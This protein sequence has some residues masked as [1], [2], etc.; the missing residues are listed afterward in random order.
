M[1]LENGD[2]E[3]GSETGFYNCV[4]YPYNINGR[5]LGRAEKKMDKWSP[6][7]RL[8]GLGFYIGICIVAGILG[9]LWLDSK[10]NTQPIF[11][12]VGLILGLI[13]A[14]WGTYQM[15]LP[16]INNNKRERR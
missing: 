8:I 9:G 16:L 7:L 15:I 13:L 12:L 14:F 10:F 1:I 5:M 6:A 4:I 11:L 2:L 3:A